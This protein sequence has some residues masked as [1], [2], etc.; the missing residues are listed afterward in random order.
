MLPLCNT[1][2]PPKSVTSWQWYLI[3]THLS[4]DLLKFKYL[5]SGALRKKYPSNVGPELEWSVG[6]QQ[7][8][9]QQIIILLTQYACIDYID[10]LA[11]EELKYRCCWSRMCSTGR[12]WSAGLAAGRSSSGLG[13]VWSTRSWND[14]SFLKSRV[15]LMQRWK[16]ELIKSLFVKVV[17]FCLQT[18]L[19]LCQSMRLNL[20]YSRF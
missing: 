13:Q 8:S 11:L 18:A 7:L 19:E 12:C 3:A 2:P 6:S 1:A 10:R 15:S 5:I 14:Q 17:N 16:L 9:N 20:P 4:L